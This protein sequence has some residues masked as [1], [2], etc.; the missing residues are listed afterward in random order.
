[1]HEANCLKLDCSKINKIFDWNPCWN[2]E[3]SLNMTIQFTKIWLSGG[4]V[5]KEMDTEIKEF[6]E[7]K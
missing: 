3:K 4:N 1:M 6:I 2:I 5:S 7:G